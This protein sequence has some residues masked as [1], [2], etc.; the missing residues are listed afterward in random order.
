MLYMNNLNSAN[1]PAVRTGICIA[2]AKTDP[3]EQSS[4]LR[5]SGVVDS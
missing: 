1:R 2:V 4:V 3:E 5:R